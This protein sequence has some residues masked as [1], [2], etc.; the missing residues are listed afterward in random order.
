MTTATAISLTYILREQ[1]RVL[2]PFSSAFIQAEA[3]QTQQAGLLS[4]QSL[5]T[6]EVE[7]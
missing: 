2:F 6:I 4:G 3:R 5:P 7:P 1:K